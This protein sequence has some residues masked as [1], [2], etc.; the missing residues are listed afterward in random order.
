MQD[1]NVC[2]GLKI[3]R[4]GNAGVN[5]NIR[6][7]TSEGTEETRAELE[8]NVCAVGCR[9]LIA[10][11]SP[12]N[13]EMNCWR[14]L[15]IDEARKTRPLAQTVGC[16][17]K[18]RTGLNLLLAFNGVCKLYSKKRA[19][20]ERLCARGKDCEEHERIE[21][22]AEGD[23]GGN[24]K[25]YERARRGKRHTRRLPHK[26]PKIVFSQAS[27]ELSFKV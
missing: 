14:T 16:L 4:W 7:L 27:L 3:Q 2:E 9:A 15:R 13:R 10:T 25:L 12:K 1:T 24:E 11:R 17:S 23:E 6:F 8:A 19:R 22:S 18:F 20:H 5:A 21:W 26:L